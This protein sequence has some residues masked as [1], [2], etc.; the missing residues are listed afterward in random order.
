MA[1]R[2][3]EVAPFSTSPSQGNPLLCTVSDSYWVLVEVIQLTNPAKQNCPFL[4]DVSPVKSA[5]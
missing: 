2:D 1:E 5:E 4:L 3:R